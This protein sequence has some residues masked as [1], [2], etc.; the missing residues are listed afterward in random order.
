MMPTYICK[1]YLIVR[2]FMFNL[3]L[4]INLVKI[5]EWTRTSAS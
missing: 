2:I 1:R 3:D 5:K 4:E